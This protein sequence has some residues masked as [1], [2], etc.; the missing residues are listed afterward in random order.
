MVGALRCLVIAV[1]G[2]AVAPGAAVG[3]ATVNFDQTIG[4][5]T[6]TDVTGVDDDITV[7]QTPTD[8]V[9]SRAGGGLTFVGDCTGGG[10]EAV[11]CPRATSIAVDLGAGS[12][13]FSVLGATVPI[14]VAGQA[15]DDNLAGGAAGDVLAGGDG[16]DVLNGFGGVDDYFGESGDDTIEARDGAAERIAC[17]GG[18]DQ[19]QNDFVDILAECERGIDGDGDGFS[20]AVDC[21]DGAANLFPGAREVFDNGVDEDCNGRDDTNLDR[22]GDGFAVPGDCDDGNAGIR[23]GALEI[24]G[25]AVDENCDRRTD[26]FARL[27]AVVSIRWA[28][29]R[30]YTRLRT[31]VVRLAPRGAQI[32]LSCRGRS[33]PSRRARRRTVPRDLARV[34]L[35]SG[36]GRARLRPGTR[37]TLTIVA[38]G[39]IGRTYTYTVKRGEL[40]ESRTVCRAPSETKGQAC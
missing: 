6:I 28:L 11:Q 5:L 9:V 27:A 4:I 35:H 19:A 39:A 14:S 40:P 33:C 2:L 15:G 13:R 38:P 29:A 37:L 7:A 21:N 3:D 17:G 8:H 22:D 30:T 34:T 12:D 31:L 18:N 16:N 24:R 1:L 32:V 23:P 36:F 25:N 10:M 20:S 26:P